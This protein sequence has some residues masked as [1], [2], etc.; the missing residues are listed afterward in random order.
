MIQQSDN[1][2]LIDMIYH[3]TRQSIGFKI[4]QILSDIWG[5]GTSSQRFPNIQNTYKEIS[6]LFICL[7]F[8]ICGEISL[9]INYGRFSYIETGYLWNYNIDFFEIFYIIKTLYYNIISTKI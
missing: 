2:I 5:I 8:K 4:D 1:H 3:S 9:K 6:V 7:Y